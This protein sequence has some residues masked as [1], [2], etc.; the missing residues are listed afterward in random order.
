MQFMLSAVFNHFKL[1][2]FN[3]KNCLHNRLS[4]QGSVSFTVARQHALVIR[5]V[6][7]FESETWVMRK[8]EHYLLDRTEMRM[9][10]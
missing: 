1:L 7:L 6:L 5:P 3:A 8:A 10:R 4:R 9:L 2:T